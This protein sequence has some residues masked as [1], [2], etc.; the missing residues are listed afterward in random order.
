MMR[1]LRKTQMPTPEQ[2]LPGRDT[3]M[4]VP[5][6]HFVTGNPLQPPFPD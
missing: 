5:E 4:P 3:R 6:P 2:A 1:F